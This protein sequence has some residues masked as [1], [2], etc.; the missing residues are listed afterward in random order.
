MSEKNVRLGII[1]FGAQGG[2]YA[3]LLADGKIAGMTL[4]AIADTLGV[5]RSTLYRNVS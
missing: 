5:A 3:G 1:G 2:M 4:G